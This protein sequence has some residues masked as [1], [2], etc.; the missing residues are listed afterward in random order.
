VLLV[1]E[2]ADSTADYDRTVK[3]PRYARAGI[4]VFW[5]VDLGTESVDVASDPAGDAYAERRRYGRGDALPLPPPLD[6]LD[7]IPVA[8]VMGMGDE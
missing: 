4:P 6:D 7:P 1:V 8:D 2:V 5:L 3:Q